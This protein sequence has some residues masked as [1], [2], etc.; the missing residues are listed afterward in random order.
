MENIQKLFRDNGILTSNNKRKSCYLRLLSLNEKLSHIWKDF[1]KNYRSE[2]EAWFCLSHLVK[3][4]PRCPICGRLCKFTGITKY[5]SNGYLTTCGNCSA[6]AVEDKKEK[7]SKTMSK[8]TIEE[9]RASFEKRQ[10]TN[11]ERFGD[12][13]ATLFGSKSFKENLKEKYGSESFNNRDKAKKTCKEKYGVEYNFQ[14]EGFVEKSLKKKIEKY[15]NASNFEKVKQTNLKRY[16]CENP[17]QNKEICK[18]ALATKNNNS[19]IFEKENDCVSVQELIHKYGQG[20]KEAHIIDSFLIYKGRK[21]VV[22]KDIKKIEDYWNEGKC[23]TNEYISKKEKDLVLFIKSI[24]KGPI[25]ENDTSI[26]P[27]L[28]HRFYELDIFLPELRIAFDFDGNYYHSS[29][30]KDKYYHQRKSLCCYKQ[31]VKLAHILE[32]DWDNDQDFIKSK[33]KKLIFDNESFDDGFFPSNDTVN[34]VLS[35]PRKKLIGNLEYFDTGV[36]IEC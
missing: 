14:I 11:L 36:K 29:I 26:V 34:I 21:Y 28:N 25:V 7:F 30:F 9:K 8:K 15:G 27:N 3:E 17:L 13:N 6:N 18:K 24:Y 5:G 10:Q 12:K 33:I 1:S 2:N 31:N 32:Y 19:D 23:H 35:E 4:L 20:W 16:G 22:N